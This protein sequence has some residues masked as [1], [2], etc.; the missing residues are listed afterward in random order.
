MFRAPRAVGFATAAEELAT[1]GR[2]TAINSHHTGIQRGARSI[3]SWWEPVGLDTLTISLRCEY[4]LPI[5]A[6]SSWSICRMTTCEG[7]ATIPSASVSVGTLTIRVVASSIAASPRIPTLVF[8]CS[9]TARWKSSVCSSPSRVAVAF[10]AQVCAP[11]DV[12]DTGMVG[13]HG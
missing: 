1:V 7:G 10:F 5:A 9:A 4:L 11:D 8:H 3:L 2:H 6:C 12:H 13:V